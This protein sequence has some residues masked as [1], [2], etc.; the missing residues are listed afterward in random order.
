MKGMELDLI[1]VPRH[2]IVLNCPELPLDEVVMVL[3]NDL[4]G[5]AVWANVPPPPV[6]VSKPLAFKE[7]DENSLGL[8]GVFPACAV[9]HA[10]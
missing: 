5:S 3:G 2:F 10:Q 1:P 8:P 9:T 7:L 4:A 6:V